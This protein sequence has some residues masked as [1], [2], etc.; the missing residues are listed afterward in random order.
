VLQV[1]GAL[2]PMSRDLPRGDRQEDE[3][4]PF[5]DVP[6]CPICQ[7]EGRPGFPLVLADSGRWWC[8]RHSGFVDVGSSGTI[9]GPH[10]EA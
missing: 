3:K 10:E 6:N 1:S 5:V 8:R 7:D 4:P 9:E 2:E